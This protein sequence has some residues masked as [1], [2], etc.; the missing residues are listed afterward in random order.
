M[1]AP[2]RPTPERHFDVTLVLGGGNALGAFQAG[3]YEALHESGLLPEW[4]VGTSIG[5]I[6]GAVIAGTEPGSRVE[7]LKSLWQPSPLGADVPGIPMLS[8]WETARRTA[9]ASWT[10][11]AGRSGMFGPPLSSLMTWTC[12]QP[13]VF[14]TN[15]LVDT[16]ERLVDFERLNSGACRFTATAVDLETGDDV[17]FDT[18]K[19]RIEARHIRASAALPI[20]FPPVEIEGRWLVDGGLSANLPLD[21]VWSAPT[22][23]PMLC[24]AVDLM[25][26][27]G[28]GVPRTIGESASRLQD[29]LFAAQSRRS[30]DRWQTMDANRDGAGVSLVRVAYVAQELEVAGKAMDFSGPTIEHRWREGLMARNSLRLKPLANLRASDAA[31]K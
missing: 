28:Q 6:N 1:D 12:D 23:R 22:S 21:P 13:S 17:V 4:V 10:M 8:H 16:L 7:A 26:L 9:A 31:T 3:V 27:G 5:A 19:N 2:S 20:A 24:V 15:Q 14:E 29:I 25:P 11:L 30:I 18:R